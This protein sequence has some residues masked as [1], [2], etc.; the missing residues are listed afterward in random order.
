MKKMSLLLIIGILSIALVGG[1]TGYRL[2]QKSA[3]AADS[4]KV[5]KTLASY[6]DQYS[7]YEDKNIVGLISAKEAL[8]SLESG[9]IRWSEVIKKVRQTIP[10]KDGVPLLEVLSYT[11][12]SGNAISMNVKTNSESKN[13][14]F[15][16][17]DLIQAFDESPSFKDSFVPS[18]SSGVDAGGLPVLTFALTTTY[19]NAGL[20]EEAVTR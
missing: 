2:W 14:Y 16:A 20:G 6:E 5:D 3:V 10:K 13:S 8:V 19:V 9:I 1:Y 15:D 12:S 17:A 4:K 11:G 7:Q 18:I